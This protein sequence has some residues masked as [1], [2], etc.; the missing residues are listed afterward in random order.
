M[1]DL[2]KVYFILKSDGFNIN[3]HKGD[4]VQIIN[5]DISMP[6]SYLP[7]DFDPDEAGMFP[8]LFQAGEVRATVCKC[9]TKTTHN[10]NYRGRFEAFFEEV[11]N[12]KTAH[13][14]YGSK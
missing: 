6:K 9:S 2:S 8:D 5:I 12:H 4:I 1:V 7:F 11:P 3:L 13:I 14:L 10:V